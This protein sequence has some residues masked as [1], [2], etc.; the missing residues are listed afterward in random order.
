VSRPQAVVELNYADGLFAI[1]L[2]E[3]GNLYERGYDECEARARARGLRLDHY[4][5][6]GSC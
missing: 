5:V 2:V 3:G 6:A 1:F 4:R